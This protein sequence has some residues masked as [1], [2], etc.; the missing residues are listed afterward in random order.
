MPRSC[1]VVSVPGEEGGWTM[2]ELHVDYM[3]SVV[4]IIITTGPSRRNEVHVHNDTLE[5]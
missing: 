5:P 4:M 3:I 2:D 1:R